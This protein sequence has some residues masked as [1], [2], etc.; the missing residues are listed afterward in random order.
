MGAI[1][2]CCSSKKNDRKKG[3]DF[4][5]ELTGQLDVDAQ[6]EE[7]KDE[8]IQN[9][10]DIFK[11]NDIMDKYLADNLEDASNHLD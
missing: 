8:S 10:G 7:T 2:N 3:V 9:L 11:K 6:I 4:D 5:K 1:T